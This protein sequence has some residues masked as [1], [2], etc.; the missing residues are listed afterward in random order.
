MS[1]LAIVEKYCQEISRDNTQSKESRTFKD[2]D[3]VV[4][5]DGEIDLQAFK[6]NEAIKQNEMTKSYESQIYKEEFEKLA[7]RVTNIERSLVNFELVRTSSNV[8]TQQ[9]ENFI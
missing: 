8:L 3:E 1:R 7:S 5:G 4:N 9:L 6:A 2:D